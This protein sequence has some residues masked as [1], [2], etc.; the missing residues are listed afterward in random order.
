MNSKKI[1]LVKLFVSL[2]FVIATAGI[3]LSKEIS[4]KNLI[5]NSGFEQISADNPSMP[6]EY[7]LPASSQC[8][9]EN[10]YQGKRCLKLVKDKDL[11]VSISQGK[12]MVEPDT[13]YKFSV[14]YRAS[15]KDVDAK[16]QYGPLRMDI[17]ADRKYMVN[18]SFYPADEWRKE[19]IYFDSGKNN[20]IS[21][22]FGMHQGKHRG[23]M[24]IDNLE[25][26]A[27]TDKDYQGNFVENGDFEQ[28]QVGIIPSG[29][30]RIPRDGIFWEVD[31]S[32]SAKGQRSFKINNTMG[33]GSWAYTKHFPVLPSKVYTFSVW[34]KGDTKPFGKTGI[35]VWEA[36][37]QWSKGDAVKIY[38]S[39]RKYE[40][41]FKVPVDTL[42]KRAWIRIDTGQK[43]IMW[44]DDVRLEQTELDS[45]EAEGM[46]ETARLVSKDESFASDVFSEE[47]RQSKSNT[48]GVLFYLPFEDQVVARQAKGKKEPNAAKGI[49]YVEG[50]K[51][52][53]LYSDDETYLSYSM[54]DNLNKKQGSIELWIKPDWDV[55]DGESYRIFHEGFFVH[56]QPNCLG[57]SKWLNRLYLSVSSPDHHYAYIP[58]WRKGEWH[59]IVLTWDN[60]KGAW[61]YVDGLA[62]CITA[63]RHTWRG[64][65][66]PQYSWE[67]KFY[68][69]MNIGTRLPEYSGS[70]GAHAA[71]DEFCI[72]DH[73][74]TSEQ[75][76]QNYLRFKPVRITLKDTV[77]S[78]T[79][80]KHLKV[81]LANE[82]KRP[83]SGSITCEVLNPSGAVIINKTVENISFGSIEKRAVDFSFVPSEPGQHLVRCTWKG[84]TTY[85]E[86]TRIYVRD[87]NYEKL[88]ISE[89]DNLKLKLIDEIDCTVS[90]GPERYCDDG[91]AKVV[92]SPLG[93][94]R[95][96]GTERRSRFAYR[97][98][99]GTLRNPHLLIFEYP[100]DKVRSMEIT[101]SGY[102]GKDV[103]QSWNLQTGILTGDEYPNTNRLH[104]YKCFLWPEEKDNALVIMN[105]ERSEYGRSA[106]MKSIKV[107]EIEGGL[108][109]AGISKVKYGQERLIGLIYEDPML[110]KCFGG[111][112]SGGLPSMEE[113]HRALSRLVSY[114]KYTGQNLIILPIAWYSGPNY[115]SSL[116]SSGTE[117]WERYPGDTIDFI[118]KMF[119]KNDLSFIGLFR[120]WT[121]GTLARRQMEVSEE[122]V[123]N[124]ADTVNQMMWNNEMSYNLNPLHPDVQKKFL[125]LTE[126]VLDRYGSSPAFKGI[127][128]V[129]GHYSGSLT[130]NERLKGGYGDYNTAFFEKDTGIK[131]PVDKKSPY[132]FNRRYDWL[133]KNKKQ[134]W[135]DWRCRKIHELTMKKYEMIRNKRDDLRMIISPCY[136]IP[137]LENTP[138]IRNISGKIQYE[139]F[140]QAGLDMNMYQGIKNF[141]FTMSIGGGG[142]RYSRT[143]GGQDGGIKS[144][145][146]RDLNFDKSYQSLY[147][148]GKSILN[149]GLG[150][151][152]AAFNP[153]EIMPM[154]GFWW[155]EPGNRFSALGPAHKNFMQMYAEGMAAI[156]PPAVV[157][158][159]NLV[160]TTGH[161]EDII[162]FA[163]AYR[164]LPAMP[165]EEVKEVKGDVVCVRELKGKDKYYFYLVNRE[166]YPVKVQLQL[167]TEKG[168]I[169]LT[170]LATG[171][172]VR[173]RR[174]GKQYIFSMELAPFSLNSFVSEGDSASIVSVNTNVPTDK[175]KSLIERVEKIREL[176]KALRI[177]GACEPDFEKLLETVDSDIKNRNYSHLR[178]VLE[179]YTA[180]DL[181]RLVKDK[182][183]FS[184][185]ETSEAFKEEQKKVKEVTAIRVVSSPKLDGNFDDP[186]WGKAN[187][188]EA[189]SQVIFKR[190]SMMVKPPDEKTVVKIVHDKENIYFGFYCYDANPDTIRIKELNQKY[191]MEGEDVDVWSSNDD[192]IEIFLAPLNDGK[193]YYQFA[194]DIG[195]NQWES[196]FNYR[197]DKGAK[198]YNPEWEVKTSLTKDGWTAEVK[199]PFQAMEKVPQKGDIW[200]LNLVRCKGDKRFSIQCI[201]KGF[202]CPETFA[203]LV[204]F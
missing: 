152:E 77:Y 131:I 13:E 71:I 94:Y 47:Q 194:S 172:N 118:L 112:V 129:Y 96:T 39:W 187:P 92:D 34:L 121:T 53:A 176:V 117:G 7:R 173:V 132:R 140:K 171:N 108:P 113:V 27:L 18:Y 73:E 134:E 64:T 196:S 162:S 188:I 4:V 199:I 195:M 161:E 126:E 37:G 177:K 183:L 25:L 107:Y 158:G 15:L 63:T 38:P 32:T 45:V 145:L 115:P 75:I 144:L 119:E 2:F 154:K 10:S 167:K 181:V 14:Y 128:Y 19:T 83:V 8:T 87:L 1:F 193:N 186:C 78:L 20:E 192:S 203:R 35:G 33:K 29:W 201:N 48:G 143:V 85:E 55:D 165:F 190:M 58:D 86:S 179:S 105:R 82:T 200:G 12:I 151:W 141:S 57:L 46:V 100:D 51:G 91:T 65:V 76:R 191:V 170:N 150:Y 146:S 30:M 148:G 42:H 24:Y 61:I 135:I 116:E 137:V 80:E 204:F 44:I 26:A 43:G 123:K 59:Q 40:Y 49:K 168:R 62:K 28:D 99:I 60:Q 178:H 90:L 175:I 185:L 84:H 52:R 182:D 136:S 79:E 31:D 122:E 50:I 157:I 180:A 133:M 56:S 68:P 54:K 164:A 163:R 160:N 98:K 95:E 3:S 103:R 101:H 69:E 198:Y 149:T 124:G 169:S 153:D 127:C 9:D 16:E 11:G 74:L 125:D 197:G 6:S 72:Y 102:N 174:V 138:S 202:H 104:E 120:A 159:W 22:I 66:T 106:A 139:G 21:V 17:S 70:K 189:F 36:C 97:F 41:M 166:Y 23:T 93:R 114:M 155:K 142:Q 130:F 5:Q 81:I 111:D 89:T 109:E 156:D 67:T 184:Y 147:D 110:I 88:Q